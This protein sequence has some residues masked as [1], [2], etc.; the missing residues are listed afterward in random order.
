MSRSGRIHDVKMK[1]RC[2]TLVIVVLG[3]VWPPALDAQGSRSTRSGPPDG[4]AA[5]LRPEALRVRVAPPR[6][7]QGSVAQVTV[8]CP[9]A[10]HVEGRF[11]GRA[12]PCFQ[13]VEGGPWCALVGID[14][15][16]SPGIRRLDL[17]VRE[18]SGEARECRVDVPVIAGTFDVQ[19]LRVAR[20]M[21]TPDPDDEERIRREAELVKK[22]LGGVTERKFEGAFGRPIPGPVGAR[23]GGRR[24]FN[25]VPRNPH[26]GVDLRGHQGTPVHAP[27]RATVALVRDLYFAG[28]CVILD[29]G[30]GLFTQYAHLSSVTVEEG[31]QVRAG[32]L[33]G[34]VGRTGRATGPH[35]HWSAT[36]CRARVNPL[37]LV[38]IERSAPADRSGKNSRQETD[39]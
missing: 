39:R 38:K 27:A 21:V 33:L 35:L 11:D 3:L 25:G 28:T 19:R 37:D 6:P 31:E 15:E 10:R 34:K 18:R 36:L 1:P 5:S 30:L 4:L 22:I 24:F 32:Q 29:H 12:V 16:A 13:W 26:A 7:A 17:V 8:D 20:R 14:L 23:F 9:L 2:V